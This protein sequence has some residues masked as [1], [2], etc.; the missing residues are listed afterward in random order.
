MPRRRGWRMRMLREARPARWPHERKLSVR[1]PAPVGTP[2]H[3]LPHQPILRRVR[4]TSP[5]RSI[6]AATCR[7]YHRA[8]CPP[9]AGSRLRRAFQCRQVQRAQRAVPADALARVSKTPGAPSSWCISSCRS[10]SAALPRRPAR[11]RLRQGAAG[12][13]GALAGLH[14]DLVPASAGAARAGGGDGHPPSAQGLRP[15]D[16]RLRGRTRIAGARA[17]DQGRQTLAR[18]GDEHGAERCGWN[19]R[20]R[21]AKASACR[22]S[23]PRPGPASSRR[24]RSSRLA[25]IAD[26]LVALEFED[27]RRLRRQLERGFPAPPVSRPGHR[28]RGRPRAGSAAKRERKQKSFAGCGSAPPSPCPGR[29]GGSTRDAVL[30]RVMHPAAAV[31]HRRALAPLEQRAHPLLRIALF[32]AEA[33]AGEGA[34]RIARQPPGMSA[35][36]SPSLRWARAAALPSRSRTAACRVVATKAIA[37]FHNPTS[38][39][40]L[41]E[42]ARVSWFSAKTTSA[43]GSG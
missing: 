24:A 36:S 29:R 11:L 39:S 34:G 10:S 19:W 38:P 12:T 4:P 37:S 42:Q 8:S 23:R 3:P 7:P 21:S 20:A 14:Q 5:R 33:L 25:G 27:G 13:A 22:R 18:R 28:A 17:A 43:P 1:G 2:C 15:A 31:Q 35:R 40:R 26:A 16:A 30:R 9:M 32:G 6:R 41:R